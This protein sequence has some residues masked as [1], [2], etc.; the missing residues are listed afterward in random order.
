MPEYVEGYEVFQLCLGR[1]P[2]ESISFTELSNS[3]GDGFEA[4]VRFGAKT[5]NRDWQITFPTLAGSSGQTSV[6]L[7]GLVMTAADYVWDFFCRHKESGKPFVIKSARNDQYY[8]ARFPMAF[9]RLTYSMMYTKLVAS[10]LI[11]TQARVKGVSVWDMTK[12]KGIYSWLRADDFIGVYNDNDSIISDWPDASASNNDFQ[13]ANPPDC[14]FQENEQNGLPIVR[15]N[16]TNS[17]FTQTPADDFFLFDILMIIKV[18]ETTT[19]SNNG[20]V[21]SRATTGGDMLKGSSGT[22]KF[23]DLGIGANEYLYRKNTI[24]FVESDQQS[25]INTFA[26]VHLRKKN[27]FSFTLGGGDIQLGMNALGTV[28]GK[29]DLGEAI[30]LSERNMLSDVFEAGEHMMTRWG[31]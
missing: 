25:P 6:T 30:F 15:F 1:E 26:L 24:E 21:I 17:L 20:G 9:N 16:G 12:L 29:I 2:Q 10:Q 8:L 11:V 19:W 23:A 28:F 5:G 13:D 4:G 31:I 27:G 18:R 22:T 7:D 3:L 14:T